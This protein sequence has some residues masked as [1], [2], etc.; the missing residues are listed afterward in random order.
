MGVNFIFL[1]FLLA[2]QH[3]SQVSSLFPFCWLGIIPHN[4][5]LKSSE[6]G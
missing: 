6:D 1:T 2:D 3:D 4:E 5:S